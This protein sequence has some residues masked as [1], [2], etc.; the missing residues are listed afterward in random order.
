MK[1]TIYMYSRFPVLRMRTILM[2][3]GFY[4][5]KRKVELHIGR[6]ARRRALAMRIF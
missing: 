4:S 6:T 3:F 1:I 5:Q 2:F